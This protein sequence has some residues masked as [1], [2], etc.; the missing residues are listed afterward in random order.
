MMNKNEN[1]EYTK[2]VGVFS[3]IY[4]IIFILDILII[5][6]IRFGYY[7]VQYQPFPSIDIYF[8]VESVFLISDFLFSQMGILVVMALV[9]VLFCGVFQSKLYKRQY[10]VIMAI[11]F[12]FLWIVLT[13]YSFSV[14][15]GRY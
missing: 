12:I 7:T 8:E 15:I 5:L 14:Y 11:I 9:T 10:M 2:L 6:L 3:I 1:N 13:W 4:S